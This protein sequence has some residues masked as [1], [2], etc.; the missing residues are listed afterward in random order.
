MVDI[1]QKGKENHTQY[2]FGVLAADKKAVSQLD[3][4][5]LPPIGA[6]LEEG[7]PIFR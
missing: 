5:G 3:P 1:A 4:D 7:D 2:E 6:L